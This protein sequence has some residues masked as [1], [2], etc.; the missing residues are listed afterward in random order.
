MLTRRLTC[1]LISSLAFASAAAAQPPTSQPAASQPALHWAAQLGQRSWQVT[2]ATK[3]ID[4]LVLV[5][6][7]ATYVDEMRKWSA[8]ERWPILFEDDELAP[9][10]V[11][12]FKPAEVIRREAVD[13]AL[14]DER[15]QK[16]AALESVVVAALGGD[17][18]AHSTQ[19]LFQAANYKPPG[20]VIAST[21]DPAWT[22]AVALAAGHAQPLLWIDDDL[23]TVRDEMGDAIARKLTETIE[24]GLRATPWSFAALGDDIDA[25]TLCRNCPVAATITVPPA[26]RLVTQGQYAD[27]TYAVSDIVGRHADGSRFAFTGWI[28]G[29]EKRSAYMAMCSLFLTHESASLLNTYS[30][31]G[32][33]GTYGMDGAAEL[34]TRGGLR[35]QSL[36]G[37]DQM[38]DAGWAR[39]LV[40]GLSSDVIWMNSGGN[41]DYFI[42]NGGQARPGD[43][44]VLDHPA[45]LQLIHSW[46]LRSPARSQ[47]VGGRWLD[48]GTYAMVGSCFEPFLASFV[49]P[50][51]LAARCL[52]GVPFLVAA[53]YWPDDQRA[54]PWRIVT[55]GDPLMLIPPTQAMAKPRIAHRAGYGE[56]VLDSARTLMKSANDS[57]DGTVYAEAIAALDLLGLDD[58][59]LQ[60][61][62]LAQ[63][64]NI[65][66]GRA[67]SAALNALFR[68]REAEGFVRAWNEGGPHSPLQYDMLWHLMGPRL[69]GAISREDL[70]TLE[71]AVRPDMPSADVE[72]LAPHLL[73]V[74]G[75]PHLQQF[76]TRQIA[77]A[78]DPEQQRLLRE[79]AG[80]Y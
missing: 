33:W 50:Q 74:L 80:R 56:N 29:D 67:A 52:G 40:G 53:R 68:K 72:R 55:I 6:D 61:W 9:M 44:P 78:K 17:P 20:V 18:R 11:R 71:A 25:I 66:S 32:E 31:E 43:V 30:S 51:A 46:S 39:L 58:I 65:T 45:A 2:Q 48:H 41:D 54:K 14:P 1:R 49:Q 57:G 15:M 59:A 42:L 37:P 21:S 7:A 26:Q 69:G 23:G 64:K 36:S 4:R 24:A 79:I 63:Q 8:A 5:P 13:V 16:R 73:R 10:F 38:G 28:F 22:A 60:M 12:R 62:T 77:A 76:I 34:L 19:G 27:G 3:V 70:M 75:K 47:T 35:V